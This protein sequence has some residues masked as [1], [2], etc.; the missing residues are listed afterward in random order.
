MM[1]FDLPHQHGSP[2]FSEKLYQIL[3]TPEHFLTA[4]EFFRLLGDPTRIR[5][6]WIL[7]HQEICVV[8]LA[9]M[10]HMSSPAI[11]HHLRALA[12][13][14]LADSRRVGKEV[15]YRGADTE[16]ARLLHRILEQ[17]MEI[18]CPEE[19]N[20]TQATPE[21]IVRQAHSY[22]VEHLS[23]RITTE[24]LSR[25]YHINPTTLKQAF[26]KYYGASIA[27]HIKEHRMERAAKALRETNDSI[28]SISRSVGYE[29]QSRFTTVFKAQYG[30]LPTEYRKQN[31]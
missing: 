28:A 14:D 1:Y 3:E 5:I 18:A 9:A 13:R 29:S 21:E 17:I 19:I 26:K 25:K 27:S 20:P 8:N 30:V 7:M 22:L 6:F 31:K 2:E 16:A 11:S 12:D 10:L 4:A 23:E 24:T 15:Y